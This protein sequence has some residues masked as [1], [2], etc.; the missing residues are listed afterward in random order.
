MMHIVTRDL[1]DDFKTGQKSCFSTLDPA[2][3]MHYIFFPE[4]TSYS[5][6]AFDYLLPMKSNFFD[7]RFLRKWTKPHIFDA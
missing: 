5:N 2:K 7:E 6:D 3:S 1:M 4:M